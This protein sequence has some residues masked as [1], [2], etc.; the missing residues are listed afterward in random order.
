MKIVTPVLGAALLALTMAAQPAHAMTDAQCTDAFT[1]ADAKKMGYLTETDGTRYFAVH[2]AINQPVTDGKLTRDQFLMNC[3]ADAYVMIDSKV[4][5]GAPL[6]GS[7]SF[8]ENQAKDRAIARGMTDVGKLT[9]DDK[10]VWR[11][12]GM[13]DGKSA[14]VAVD[15]KGNVVITQS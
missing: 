8:T 14:S 13:S 4:D 12:T 15:Y 2:R 5:A 10:G 1:K 3:K 6:P 9:K 7:N 11:G